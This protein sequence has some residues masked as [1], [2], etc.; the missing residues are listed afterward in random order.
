MGDGGVLS[1]ANQSPTAIWGTLTVTNW[2]SG[3]DHIYVNGG[4]FGASQL[5]AIAFSGWEPAGAKVESGEL[6]PTGSN[7]TVSAYDTW[8]AG[9]GVGA[10]TNDYDN[11]GL[12]NIYEY[13]L[14]GDPTNAVDQGISPVFS[15]AGGTL[16][17]IHPQLSDP[18]SGL[19]YHLELSEDLVFGTWTNAG[20]VVAGTNIVA[21]DFDYVTNEVSTTTKPKQFI[22]LIIDAR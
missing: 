6:L 11:D 19:D 7:A 3:V 10:G 9:F 12:L 1:M 17:Y 18:N 14:G 15:V 16:S 22:K 20:Y 2:D 4:S 21:G 13:G 8:A 5:S